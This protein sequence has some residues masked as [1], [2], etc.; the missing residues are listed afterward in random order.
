MESV[1]NLIRYPKMQIWKDTPSLLTNS[2]SQD[3]FYMAMSGEAINCY[4]LSRKQLE[5]M[6][7]FK[8]AQTAFLDPTG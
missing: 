4:K 3:F 1:T 2:P 5:N 7:T 6:S 8:K